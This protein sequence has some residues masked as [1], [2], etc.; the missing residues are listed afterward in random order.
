M[1]IPV[2]G[3]TIPLGMILQWGSRVVILASLLMIAS[4]LPVTQVLAEAR[5][6]IDSFGFWGPVVYVLI[7]VVAVVLMI[8]G[9][10]ITF[11]AGAFFGLWL[12][13]LVASLGSTLG[14]AL[15]FLIARHLVRARVEAMLARNRKLV[16][17]D[18]AITRG[19]W[20][21]VALLRLSPL[22]PF[23]LQNYLYGITGI[24]F[25]RAT[26]TSWIAMLP[27]TF[28]F[29]YLGSTAKAGLEAIVQ[30]RERSLGEWILIGVGLVATAVV[31]VYVSALARRALREVK[32][33]PRLEDEPVIT[34]EPEPVQGI[35][36]T[37]MLMTVIALIL[38]ILAITVQLYPDAVRDLLVTDA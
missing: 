34:P 25:W 27:A 4:Q 11:A 13:V 12:G 8:P 1:K 30:G 5:N 28:L 15:T 18:T 21:M 6:W 10:V 16:A 9:S 33:L 31:V 35:T 7:Y 2:L 20:K 3:S 37:T 19:G 17:M 23:N 36:L 38:L 14:V 29:V 26:L 22:V 24:G 32:E